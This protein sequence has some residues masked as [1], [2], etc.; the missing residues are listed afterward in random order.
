MMVGIAKLHADHR[1][2]L[3]VFHSHA[4]TAMQLD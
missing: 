2:V 4:D 1:D 3:E